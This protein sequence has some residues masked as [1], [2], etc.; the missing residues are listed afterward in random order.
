M[1]ETEAQRWGVAGP[2][3]EHLVIRSQGLGHCFDTRTE[4]AMGTIL[5]RGVV[6][7]DSNWAEVLLAVA[8]VWQGAW[9]SK[10]IEKW[11]DC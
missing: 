8:S 4:E 9:P 1:G 10:A 3:P 6:P 5:R 7:G 11:W 2:S